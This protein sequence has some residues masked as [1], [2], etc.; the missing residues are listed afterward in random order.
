MVPGHQQGG[1]GTHN[2]WLTALGSSFH[3]EE[4][5]TIDEGGRLPAQANGWALQFL[6]AVKA[7]SHLDVVVVVVV[8]FFFLGSH[9]L[10]IRLL[11]KVVVVVIVVGD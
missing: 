7:F 6:E 1:P 11:E 4:F 5:R 8:V 9:H 2:Q 3:C 10:V